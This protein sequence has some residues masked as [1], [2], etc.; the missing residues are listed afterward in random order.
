M[1]PLVVLAVLI[2]TLLYLHR[3]HR[4]PTT[5]LICT[6]DEARSL[7]ANPSTA[8]TPL[9]SRALPN[10][11][12]VTAFGINNSFTTTSL[13]H[14]KS[15]LHTASHLLKLSPSQWASMA[16]LAQ[17]L[18]PSKHT[19]T[20]H[21]IP[22]LR[23]YVLTIILHLF[24]PAY[25]PADEAVVGRL[26]QLIHALWVQSKTGAPSLASR[27]ELSEVM[28]TLFPDV[29]ENPLNL[30]LPAY[31]TLWRV[32]LRLFIEVHR[33]PAEWREVLNLY[34]Q[35]PSTERFRSSRDGVS[36]MFLVREALRLYPPTKR[37]Y[38][39]VGEKA[40]VAIDLEALQMDSKVWGE[41]V[42]IFR[43]ERWRF[44]ASERQAGEMGWMPFGEGCFVCPAKG[45]F[46]PR[47]IA[48]LV[49]AVGRVVPAEA[50]PTAERKEDLPEK[51]RLDNE[52]DG[53]VTL[54]YCW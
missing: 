7:L 45:M 9:Q 15:F 37:V 19:R 25:M 42:A 41:D 3:R 49:A 34:L 53:Y 28:R 5:T 22:F 44:V 12:L 38:R 29:A 11:R 20:L 10:Q 21:L 48:L 33:G 47:L 1:H 30:L 51:G 43:P 23:T 35:R 52:R 40:W 26:A 14:H 8:F 24:F 46:A 27:Q 13:Q 17:S 2:L 39:A 32:V 6:L 36:P 4:K 50:M 54:K 16:Q 18:L 31:E